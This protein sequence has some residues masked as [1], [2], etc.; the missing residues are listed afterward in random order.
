VLFD[1]PDV[2]NGSKTLQ[3]G[4]ADR[5]SVTPADIDATAKVRA[6]ISAG[7]RQRARVGGYVALF[8]SDAIAIMSGFWAAAELRGSGWLHPGGINL[9]LA[10][11]VLYSAVAVNQ[12]AFSIQSLSSVAESIRRALTSLML[13]SMLILL[14][15]FLL[16][17]GAMIGRGAFV[18]AVA[19]ST[20]AVGIGRALTNTLYISK[21]EGRLVDI[22]IIVEGVQ[23]P[24]AD[25]H[26]RVID[27]NA[28]GLRVDLN[29]P[30]SLDHMAQLITPFDRVIVACTPERRQV[31]SVAL[32]G[33]QVIGELLTPD[34]EPLGAVGVDEFAGIDTLVVS[35]GPLSLVNRI[36]KRIFDLAIAVPTL[37]FLSPLLLVVF[38]LIRLDSKGP[39]LFRQLRVGQSNRQFE[40]LKF[41][42]MHVDQSDVAGNQSAQRKD[43]R[44]TRVGRIIRATSI[45]E[46]PQLF[47]VV[48]GDMSIVGPR[49]HALGSLA[50]DALFWQ[51]DSQYWMRH[52]LKPGITGLAQIRGHRGATDTRMDL[53][54]R[55]QSDLEYLNGWRLSRDLAIVI[56]TIRVLIHPNAY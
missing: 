13:A 53:N 33:T 56:G 40:I 23:A 18:I 7:S 54:R 51:V 12:L 47:N 9:G 15:L 36:K 5:M 20:I 4:T 30:A 34:T 49:P 11:L 50:G 28:V 19:L 38:V 16:Q 35:R 26:Y 41:R 17:A 24:K 6:P 25:P 42:S 31:W 8:L 21:L 43:S 2:S 1:S 3:D 14:M 37:L 45:D 55:L 27:A 52:A 29:D 44:V 39:A 22:L 46:L 48:R 10:M 32:K